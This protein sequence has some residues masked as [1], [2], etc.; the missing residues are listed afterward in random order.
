VLGAGREHTA[1]GQIAALIP[2][3]LGFGQSNA[4]V[5][6]FAGSFGAASPARVARHVQHRRKSHRDTVRGS[7]LG[8]LASRQRPQVRIE[9]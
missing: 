7:L 1:I 8:R 2:A 5:R 4:D 9:G 6:V 3:H